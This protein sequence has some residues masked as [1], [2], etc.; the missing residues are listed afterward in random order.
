MNER[1]LVLNIDQVI[2]P[3]DRLRAVNPERVSEIALSMAQ[4]GGQITPIEVA[5]AD[6]QGR[7]VLISGAHRLA[8]LRRNGEHE[9]LAVVF[10]GNAQERR[11][12]E[13]D[14]NLYRHDLTPYDQA[15]FMAERLAIW[16]RLYDQSLQAGKPAK[17]Y[18]AKLAA[19]GGKRFYAEVA[20][21]FGLPERTARRMLTRWKKIDREA[22]TT[23]RGHAVTHN[24]TDL[25]ALG[26]LEPGLQKRI[27]AL[28]A[29]GD[30]ATVAV[31]KK[32]LGIGAA[33]GAQDP[34]GS[35]SRAFR[36]LAPARQSAFVKQNFEALVAILKT[37][38]FV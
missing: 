4:A 12:R 1:Q 15:A 29:R 18:S 13:I 28:L 35:L 36:K 10:D 2:L 26:R 8:A 34:V 22:W 6:A 17:R 3:S 37:G 38:G 20:G 9:V 30:V 31:A 16:E 5:P 21:A 11:L 25:D 24:G 7:H 33:S 32:R 14:E 27:A 23:L 19:P